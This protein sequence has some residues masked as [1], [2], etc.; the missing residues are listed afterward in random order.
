MTQKSQPT[1]F[2]LLMTAAIISF[3]LCTEG[4]AA[5]ADSSQPAGQTIKQ[6]YYE[7]RVYRI[8]SEPKKQIVDRYLDN[9]LVPALGRLGIDRVGVFVPIDKPEDLSIYVL[10]PYPDLETFAATNDRLFAD[11]GYRQAAREYYTLESKKDAPYLRIESRLMRAFA[12]IPVMEIP[13][14]TKTRSP[15]MFEMRIYESAN[16]EKAKLK[17]DMFNS[18]EIQIMRDTN[19]APLFFGESLISDSLPNLTYMLSA[20]NVEA[21]KKHF[22]D[23]KVHPEWKK[24]R[25]MPKYKNTVSKIT[26]VYL[27]PL[28]YSK[29]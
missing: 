27:A 20:P 18:G 2:V 11:A 12:G 5:G 9:A 1:L 29:L 16:E 28:P 24:M 13:K 14:E 22:E 6:E 10:I 21:H 8:E 25:V 4:L 7:L 23:F 17:V 26:S 19:L 15:R 3:C